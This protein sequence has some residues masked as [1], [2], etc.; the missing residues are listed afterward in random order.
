[1]QSRLL[2]KYRK[3]IVPALREEFGYKTVMAVPRVI[4]VIVY[5]GM[6]RVAVAKDT[7]MMERIANDLGKTTGQKPAARKAKQSI[8]GFKTREG[9]DV[10]M[11]VTLRGRRMY[12]FIDR[13]ISLALPRVR[14][15]QGLPISN[16]DSYGNLNIG[17]R[18]HNVF[19]EITYESLKDIFGVQ[20]TVATTAKNQKE[21]MALFRKL[22]FP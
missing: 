3:E 5:V 21:G 12:D 2:E 22:G 16:V 18:E 7:K 9:M 11:V 10:G 19:P 1:M 20:M 13:I 8:A 4:R 14:D 17:I 15:F 6:G